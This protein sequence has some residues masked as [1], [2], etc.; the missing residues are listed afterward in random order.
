MAGR[1][2]DL[3]LHLLDRQ[4]IDTDGNPV[5]NVDDVEIDESGY[6]EALLVGPQA[7]AGRLG[8][9]LGEWL[10]FWT[11]VLQGGTEPTRIPVDLLTDLGSHITVARSR[12]ELGAHRNEDRAR[13]YLIGRIPGGRRE[14]E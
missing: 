13:E 8:G 14:G 11:R 7:V 1:V 9:R 3:A 12:T 6:V 2:L 10:A 4:I 5:G